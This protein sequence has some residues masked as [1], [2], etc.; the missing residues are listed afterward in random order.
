M[1]EMR[2]QG[3][4]RGM[5][6]VTGHF[7]FEGFRFPIHEKQELKNRG[8]LTSSP[9]N[10]RNKGMSDWRDGTMWRSQRTL[11][12][13]CAKPATIHPSERVTADWICERA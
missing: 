9:S 8:G 2:S 11:G 7:Q 6:V 4:V 12:V 1:T 13:A 10:G 5:E 3:R